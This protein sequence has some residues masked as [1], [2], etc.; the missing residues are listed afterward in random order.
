ML[1]DSE[2][3]LKCCEEMLKDSEIILEYCEQNAK[4]LLIDLWPK[5]VLRENSL[6]VYNIY[7]CI[8]CCKRKI[9]IIVQVQIIY[10]SMFDYVLF[11]MQYVCYQ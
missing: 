5:N 8:C 9:Y 10:V 4:R 3:I 6:C 7:C 11:L 2:D 1:K